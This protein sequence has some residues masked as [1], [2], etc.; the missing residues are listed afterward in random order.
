MASIGLDINPTKCEVI[1]PGNIL[2]DQRAKVVTQLHELIPGAAVV[3]AAHQTLLGAPLTDAA[4]EVVLAGKRDELDRLLE[5]LHHL[6]SHS[7]F[8]LLRNCLWLPKLQ[9]VLRAAPLYRRP[10]CHHH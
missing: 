10:A 3:P 9:Y 2:T 6:D 5:R 7:A 8:F 1:L 4:A